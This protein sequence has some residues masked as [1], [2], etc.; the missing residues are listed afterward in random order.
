[1]LEFFVELSASK[2]PSKFID[3]HLEEDKKQDQIQ[4]EYERIP[5]YCQ[6]CANFGHLT[7]QYVVKEKW[8]IKRLLLLEAV[9][10]SDGDK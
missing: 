6:K 4:V 7:Y 5:L 9:M 1:M 2:P 8:C 3:L 10:D